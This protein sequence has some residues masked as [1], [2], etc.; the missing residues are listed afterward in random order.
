MERQAQ[1]SYHQANP[2][3]QQSTPLGKCKFHRSQAC[4]RPAKYTSLYSYSSSQI[5]KEDIA[6]SS[7]QEE[8]SLVDQQQSLDSSWLVVVCN[9]CRQGKSNNNQSVREG[10]DYNKF[11]VTIVGGSSR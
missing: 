2:T 4:Y 11:L 8:A 9:S 3:K 7:H 1:S 5:G 6:K 10:V